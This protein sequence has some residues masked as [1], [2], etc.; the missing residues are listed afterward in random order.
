MCR[1]IVKFG[2]C[3]DRVKGIARSRD[4]AIAVMFA[5][6]V[7]VLVGMMA[8]AY[9]LGRAWNLDTELQTA[10]DAAAL[11]GAT[12]LDGSDGSRLRAVQAAR[13]E[14]AKNFDKF[15]N[16]GTP[17]PG[18]VTYLEDV[19][20]TTAANCDGQ[21]VTNQNFQF[22]KALKPTKEVALT[23]GDA[24]FIEVKVQRIVSF[25]FAAAVGAV[26]SASPVA[27][28]VAGNNT[29]ICGTVPLMMCNPQESDTNTNVSAPFDYM[30]YV[31]KGFTLKDLGKGAQLIPGGFA[32]LAPVV[33]DYTKDI[34][35]PNT[36]W[37]EN[38]TV[39]KG[40]N[41]LGPYLAAVNPPN[42]CLGNNLV[43]QTGDIAS[44][45]KFLNMRMDIY[46][47]NDGTEFDPEYQPS[48]N[49]LTGLV[50]ADQPP[51]P[52]MAD[53][54]YSVT[55][56]NPGGIGAM[57]KP[58]KEFGPWRWDFPGKTWR[59]AGGQP[60]K[61]S[62]IGYP[63]DN[64]AYPNEAND[65][66]YDPSNN[67][68]FSP[69]PNTG[70]PEGTQDGTGE[71]AIGAYMDMQ[72]PSVSY[73]QT[74]DVVPDPSVIGT[75]DHATVTTP[76]GTFD[77]DLNGDG[78]LSRW[79]I[80]EWEMSDLA[81][82][83]PASL[84]NSSLPDYKPQCYG[85]DNLADGLPVMPPVNPGVTPDRRLIGVAV[86]NCNAVTAQGGGTGKTTKKPLPLAGG[87]PAVNIFLTEAVGELD[88][89]AFYGEIVGP[90]ANIGQS[91]VTVYNRIVLYE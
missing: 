56:N 36:A 47:K 15:A 43:V 17:G 63:R 78:H 4:G 42:I 18:E 45:Q 69:P 72:H 30:Q 85:V 71:W 50:P 55:S 52:N 5:L 54:D 33:C 73:S 20:C 41:A 77:I 79:E 49:Y 8:L 6:M 60:D 3:L 53:C 25:S 32:W 24:A 34:D 19:G 37:D 88:A 39:Q 58:V 21:A 11:A 27:R 67:C 28:A 9:D 84:E 64:C 65:A 13:S 14:L 74:Y 62:H 80:Y 76:T 1:T 82:N 66:P 51:P 48:P 46:P 22:Y 89:Q 40:A 83:M 70:I 38:C 81:N 12:Q 29:Y 31:G 16:G 57:K 2:S 59:I 90:Q 44:V 86:A 7:G 23:D 26:S 61:P 35:D 68:I 91:A 87:T 10:V 75:V